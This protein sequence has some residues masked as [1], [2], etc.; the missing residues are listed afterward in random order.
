MFTDENV[1]GEWGLELEV[2]VFEGKD[3][4][5]REYRNKRRMYI[6]NSHYQM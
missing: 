1:A 5:L 6:R 2:R 3:T 4:N